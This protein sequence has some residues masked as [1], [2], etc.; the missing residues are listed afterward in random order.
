MSTPAPT[1]P[2]GKGNKTIAVTVYFFTDDLT[3]D[4]AQT[5]PRAWA[6]GQVAV[7]ANGRH[8]LKSGSQ[9]MF[10]RMAELPGAVEDA[11]TDAGVTLRLTPCAGRLYQ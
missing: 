10:N 8:G 4:P 6:Q 7:Q 9:V 2:P 3:E 5:T 11:L 1:P